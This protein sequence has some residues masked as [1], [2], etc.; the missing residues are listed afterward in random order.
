MYKGNCY[1]LNNHETKI[2]W[3]EAEKKCQ[4]KN[5]WLVDIRD[6]NEWKFVKNLGLSGVLWQYFI[7]IREVNGSGIW[8]YHDGRVMNLTDVW[9]KGDPNNVGGAQD[10]VSLVSGGANRGRFND[11]SC[12]IKWDKISYIC[13]TRQY[14]RSLG[15]I[16]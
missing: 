9:R 4:A 8:T 15:E 5:A 11:L 2:T 1:S 16:V 10:C 7:G 14:R 12:N 13:K 6:K 3:H